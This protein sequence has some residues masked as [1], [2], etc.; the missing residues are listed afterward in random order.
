MA[1]SRK[2]VLKET[3]LIAIGELICVALMCGVYALIGKFD[4]SVL[5]GALVGLLVATGN[6]FFLAMIAT[7]AA[8][9][10]ENQDVEG[11]QKLMKS[12]YPIRLL[13][14]AVVLILCAKSGFFDVIALVLPLLFVRPVITIA[15]FFRK[16]GV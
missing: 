12:S 11:G 7:L 6:F 3:A 4:L 5:L 8:D 13:A 9:R 10:A 1:E 16:K 2:L 15:E 14:M